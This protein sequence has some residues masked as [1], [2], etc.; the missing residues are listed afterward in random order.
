LDSYNYCAYVR[1]SKSFLRSNVSKDALQNTYMK[2]SHP[3]PGP[4]RISEASYEASPISKGASTKKTLTKTTLDA[5]L[6][7]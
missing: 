3:I 1:A 6:H 7:Y 5:P 4:H 2:I